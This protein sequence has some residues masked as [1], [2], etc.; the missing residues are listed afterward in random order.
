MSYGI[1]V[2]PQ[3]MTRINIPTVDQAHAQPCAAAL[4]DRRLGLLVR[5]SSTPAIMRQMCEA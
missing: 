4:T 3:T 5:Y 1:G 2:I